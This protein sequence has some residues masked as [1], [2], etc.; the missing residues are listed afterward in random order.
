MKR[1]TQLWLAGMI[2]AG[3]L[4]DPSGA[5][6]SSVPTQNPTANPG[7]PS[8]GSY[9]RAVRKDK[10]AKPTAKQFDNDNLPRENK[11]SVVGQTPSKS[12][13]AAQQAASSD[14]KS[15]NDKAAKPSSVKPGQSEA[16]RQ[17]VY[18]DWKGK[19]SD[20]Q[21][22]VDLLTR[23]LDVSQREYR[24]REQAFFGD[25]GDRLRNQAEWDKEDAQYKQQIAEKQQALDEAKQ[26]KT[27][28]QEDARKAGVP[29]SVLESDQ[30]QAPPQQ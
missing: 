8:L 22:Q 13:D 7:D 5:Q 25:A 26:K 3:V 20:Q 24:L 30:T 14:A 1:I 12:A 2:L 27:D 16:E 21:G 29:S 19:I 15:A 23:E 9:A 11:L 4:V 10:T 6:D 17:Q 28:L 18:A